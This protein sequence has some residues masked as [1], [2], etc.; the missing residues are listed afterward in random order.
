MARRPA[1]HPCPNCGVHLMKHRGGPHGLAWH[2][3]TAVDIDIR[4]QVHRQ[5][6]TALTTGHLSTEEARSCMRKMLVMRVYEEG[7][8]VREISDAIEKLEEKHGGSGGT[9]PS[10]AEGALVGFM[11]GD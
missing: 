9:A 8:T 5:V 3:C 2:G 1:L 11:V 7:A 4:M 6:V 10:S